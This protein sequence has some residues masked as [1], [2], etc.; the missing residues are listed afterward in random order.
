MQSRRGR[1][2]GDFV[3]RE[4]RVKGDFVSQG[5][6][7]HEGLRVT[8]DFVSREGFVSQG[9]LCH[10]GL[11]VTGDFV[12]SKYCCC[13]TEV[14]CFHRGVVVSHQIYWWCW[15]SAKLSEETGRMG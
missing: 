1:V 9:N 6:S 5:N 13:V 15:D 14:T 11:R 12:S 3:S 10:V 2:T 8:G 7:C 4:G